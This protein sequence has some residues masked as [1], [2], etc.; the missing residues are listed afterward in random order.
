[1]LQTVFDINAGIRPGW[2]V[3]AAGLCVVALDFLRS[4]DERRS[5]RPI[6]AAA[7]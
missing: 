6:G 3:L 7:E 5:R 2:Q 1:V 4:R